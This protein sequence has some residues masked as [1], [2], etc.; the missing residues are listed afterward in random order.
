MHT[1]VS[2]FLSHG[3]FILHA[4]KAYNE[5]SSAI[6]HLHREAEKKEPIFFC[7]HLFNTWQETGELFHIH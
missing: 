5:I 6:I 4:F 7:M 1:K 2:F 3:V